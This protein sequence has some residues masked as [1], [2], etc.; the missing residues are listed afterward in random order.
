MAWQSG[1]PRWVEPVLR[2]PLLYKIVVANGVIVLGTALSVVVATYWLDTLFTGLSQLA[3]G[4]TIALL[5]LIPTLFLNAFIVSTALSPLRDLETTALRIQNGSLEARI[6]PSPIADLNQR[7]VTAALNAMLDRLDEQRGRQRELM[8]MVIEA[9]DAERRRISE[10]ILSDPAQILSSLLLQLRVLDRSPQADDDKRN[11]GIARIREGLVDS[12]KGVR[13]IAR[14][15]RP[16]ELDEL[17]LVSALE[18]LARNVSEKAD[19]AVRIDAKALDR[20]RVT[21][22]VGLTAYR[23]AQEGLA[24]ALRHAQSAEVSVRLRSEEDHLEITIRDHGVGFD[25]EGV[26]AGPRSAVGLISM[27]ERASRAKGSLLIRSHPGGGT[28]IELRLPLAI[29]PV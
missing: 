20:R 21:P 27:M 17:G 23:I 24:N 7:R 22:E 2:I 9:E 18:V 10:E 1:L 14:G 16:P 3:L 29:S 5:A 25:V 6:P 28:T 4:V 26:I 15:L 8:A 12:L 19:I 11:E 13:R